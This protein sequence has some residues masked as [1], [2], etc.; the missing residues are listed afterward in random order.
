[1]ERKKQELIEEIR[2]KITAPSKTAEQQAF[3]SW[4]SVCKPLGSLGLLE[5]AVIRL[6]GIYDDP[7]VSI[8]K[9]C[10]LVVCADHG[11][12]AEQISQ[13]DSSVTAQVALALANGT[14]NINVMARQAG[15]EVFAIDAGMKEDVTHPNLEVRKIAHG[16]GNIRN[17]RAMS[18][19]Q[20]IAAIR[21]GID[22]VR[23][24][25]EAGM[26]IIVTGEMGIGNTTITSAL[27]SVLLHIPVRQV[28]GKGAGLSDAGLEHKIQVIEEAIAFHQAKDEDMLELMSQL[29]GIELAVMTGI[30][31]GGAIYRIPIII[32]GVISSVCALLAVRI[33]P[34]C[35][36]YMFA[37]HVSEEPA[38]M[39]LLQE[40]GL[41]PLI[42]A[43]MRLGEGTGGV[44]LLPLLDLALAE[45][46]H[47]HRF[48]ETAI[49]AYVPL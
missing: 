32:D 20:V 42:H 5:D 14:S 12:V 39:L 18:I 35:R 31:L 29:G 6:A 33:A 34:V 3:L 49:D 19:D 13:S 44:C 46:H 11:V 30:F 8:E 28:T 27:S 41:K 43:N 10:V 36:E 4:Q 40:L 1:M 26:N 25:K 9:R 21:L 47:A 24:K 45:Y 7:K 15:A 23:A 16:T 2:A 48:S 17:E 22:E 38:G 37:S